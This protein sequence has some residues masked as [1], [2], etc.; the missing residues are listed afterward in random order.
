MCNDLAEAMKALD[1]RQ[2]MDQSVAA[3]SRRLQRNNTVL[4][5]L[6][7]SFEQQHQER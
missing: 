6:W 5:V 4:P 1:G 2:R 3:N 7:R